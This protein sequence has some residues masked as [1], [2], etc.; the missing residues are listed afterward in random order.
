MKYFKSLEIDRGRMPTYSLEVGKLAVITARAVIERACG[1][2]FPASFSQPP[3]FE[4]NTGV[5]VTIN[6]YPSLELR[7]CIGYPEPVY[8]LKEAIVK[9]AYG[10]TRDPRFNPLSGEE[11]D[12]VVVEVSILTPPSLIKV[13]DPKEYLKKV[14]IGRDGLIAERGPYRGL[15]LPQVPVEWNWE[16]E[17]FLSQTCMKAGLTPDAWLEKSSKFY[18]FQAEI[19]SEAAPKGDITRKELG[20]K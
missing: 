4:K 3:E 1:R 2:T 18:A 20:G 17:E 11:L 8:P 15:L 16:V 9:A 13:K 6:R 10:A 12:E 7:G 19:F 14:K 5:F